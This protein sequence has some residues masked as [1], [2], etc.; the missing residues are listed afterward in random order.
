MVMNLVCFFQCLPNKTFHFKK[1]KGSGGKYSKVR[2]TGMAAGN[3][4]GERLP[5]LVIGKSKNPRCFKG[6]KRVPCR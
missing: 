3:A 6:V 2:L 4:K 1:D 5:M